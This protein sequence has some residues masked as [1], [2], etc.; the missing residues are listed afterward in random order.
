MTIV[1]INHKIVAIQIQAVRKAFP[2]AT[3][4]K[5]MGDRF[6]EVSS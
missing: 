6:L 1:I 2:T 5:G 3:L 4:W